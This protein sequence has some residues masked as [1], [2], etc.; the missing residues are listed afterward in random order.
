[1]STLEYGGLLIV[2]VLRKNS[3]I[4]ARNVVSSIRDYGQAQLLTSRTT[5]REELHYGKEKAE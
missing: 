5:S 1:M 3:L 4:N 2:P